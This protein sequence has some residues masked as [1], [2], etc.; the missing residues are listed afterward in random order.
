MKVWL[1]GY[2]MRIR[3]NRR[4]EQACLD[5]LPFIW[6]TGNHAP[7]HNTL[8]RFFRS[9][10][11]VMKRL[12]KS[13]V[14]VAAKADLIGMVLHA[15]DGTKLKSRSSNR[16]GWHRKSLEKALSR[17]DASIDEALAT[18]DRAGESDRNDRSYE[19]S[20]RLP[21]TLQDAEVRR[22]TIRAQLAILDAEELNH[23]HPLEPDARMQQAGP[24]RAFGYNAQ[25]VVDA[26]H[27]LV[28]A[29]TVVVDENDVHQ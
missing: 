20:Y 13:V 3:S 7:D 27:G 9:H 12:F 21:S 22:S 19:P 28:V 11:P 24:E 5:Q 1:Y 2:V 14:Q 23:K 25:A 26:K 6:L 17:L 18:I 10:R 16:T 15:V 4:L 8:W 29:E